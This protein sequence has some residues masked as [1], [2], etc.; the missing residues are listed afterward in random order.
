MIIF[1]LSCAS[2]KRLLPLQVCSLWTNEK[3]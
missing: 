1:V 3:F 2:P